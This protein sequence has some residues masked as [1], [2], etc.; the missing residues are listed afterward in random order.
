VTIPGAVKVLWSEPDQWQLGPLPEAVSFTIG[1]GAGRGTDRLVAREIVRTLLARPTAF[2]VEL[3]V[4]QGTRQAQVFV[5][6][7]GRK[8]RQNAP[9]RLTTMIDRAMGQVRAHDEPAERIRWMPDSLLDSL[10]PSDRKALLQLGA[11]RQ[12]SPG[13]RLLAEGDLT[14][15]AIIILDGYVKIS[16]VTEGGMESLLAIRAAG[17]V[18]GELAAL[19]GSPRSATAVA[20]GAV[21]GRVLT[22]PELDD[23]FR[24]H[25]AIAVGFNRAVAAKLRVAT[26]HRVDFRGRDAKERLARALL[27]LFGDPAGPRS[28]ARQGLLLTQAELAGLIG[29]SESAVYKALRD[30]REAGAVDTSYRRLTITDID[31]LRDIATSD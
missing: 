15:F 31:A 5:P 27:E 10:S 25:P 26:R 8:G 18:V 20:A 7:P 11:R 28:R 16:A 1:A 4:R 23:C 29:A 19:D 24:R 22:K 12:Y 9:D 21:L 3:Y 14:T 2:D 6:G 17:D 30:L 13:A